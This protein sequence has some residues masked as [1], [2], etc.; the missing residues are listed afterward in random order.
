MAVVM[1][2]HLKSEPSDM[3][4]KVAMP[5]GIIFWLLS[6]ACLVSGAYIYYKTIVQYS[7]RAALVQS[8]WKTEIVSISR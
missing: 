7:Q 2:F 6:L 5:L 1:S 4:L 3:E 8:D